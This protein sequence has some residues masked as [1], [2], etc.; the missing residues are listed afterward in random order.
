MA[1]VLAAL[2]REA[3]IVLGFLRAPQV[4]Y[5]FDLSGD[6]CAIRRFWSAA[7]LPIVASIVTMSSSLAGM[8]AKFGTRK[9]DF[10]PITLHL[11][12]LRRQSR[13]K[14]RAAGRASD[15][16]PRFF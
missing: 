6:S 9:A 11:V 14:F 4:G 15:R 8:E 10:A 5:L 3:G 12:T 16:S 2:S 13:K 7:F 1:L